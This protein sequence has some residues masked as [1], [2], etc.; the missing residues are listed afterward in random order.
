MNH[1]VT[2]DRP[3][4]KVSLM[5]S[6]DLRRIFTSSSLRIS[7]RC[8][9]QDTIAMLGYGDDPNQIAILELIYNY[10]V[11]EY[12]KGNAYSHVSFFL[13]KLITR[14][15]FVLFQFTA[16]SPSSLLIK[17]LMDLVFHSRLPS[18]LMMCTKVLKLS[19]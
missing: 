16:F 5:I 13:L 10:D 17:P 2:I 14:V 19:N 15:S 6:N 7:P 9:V 3:E 4:E 12:T 8:A 18:V 11:T 1:I